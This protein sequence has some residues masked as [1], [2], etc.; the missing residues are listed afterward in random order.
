MSFSQQAR[1]NMIAGQMEPNEVLN[2]QILQ[3]VAAVPR[4]AFVPEA[5][6]G[7]AYL[8]EDIPV[9]NGRYLMEP[10]VFGRLLQMADI[11]PTDKVLIIGCGTGYSAAVV[12]LLT[13]HVIAIE[14]LRELSDAARKTLRELD[15][16]VELFTSAL[17][18]GYPMMA[19]YDVILIEGAVQQIPS[20]LTDQLA[21]GGRLVTVFNT[22]S[23]FPGK[24]GVGRA[25]LL[26]KQGGQLMRQESFDASVPVLPGFEKKTSF[27]F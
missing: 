11:Q 12:S 22:Q 18:V 7:V 5:L 9:G 26:R 20:T 8:D 1:E 10:R 16:K 24:A 4:E 27:E 3:S 15:V 21:E 14:C 25:L 2:P 23:P 19:P 13:D 17:T 6:S